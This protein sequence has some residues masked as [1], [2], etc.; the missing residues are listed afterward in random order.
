M[1]SARRQKPFVHLLLWASV[2]ALGI[3][4]PTA[5]GGQNVPV[6]E[7]ISSGEVKFGTGETWRNVESFSSPLFVGTKVR[8]EKGVAALQLSDDVRIE[9]GEQSLLSLDQ[10][11]VLVLGRGS[12][13]F[14]IPST[15]QVTFKAGGLLVTKSHSDQCVVGTMVL[16]PEGSLTVKALQGDL[17][18]RNQD[19]VIL[20]RL[21][22]NEAI[23]IPSVL[24]KTPPKTV[25]ALTAEV[26]KTS[27]PTD[28]LQ[29]RSVGFMI[30]TE[31]EGE[32]GV[33]PSPG[34]GGLF[35]T[36]RER[37]RQAICP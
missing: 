10:K 31:S 19:Q 4:L 14:R 29:P 2:F 32:K 27:E 11:E 16:R 12:I 35:P 24:V 26:V 36:I 13:R 8:T 37:V 17:S 15:S 18:V 21:A 30:S 6:G 25:A 33:T 1:E 23:T 9:L 34:S 20:T 7:M 5:H 28:D 22:A 3:L